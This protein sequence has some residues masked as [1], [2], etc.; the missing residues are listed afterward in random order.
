MSEKLLEEKFSLDGI[1]NVRLERIGG[2]TIWEAQP[3]FKHQTEIF[4]IQKSIRPVQEGAECGCVHASDVSVRFP[5]GSE[6]RPDIAIFC[7]EPDE[8][9]EAITLIPAAVVEII[10]KGYEAKDYEVG[11]PFYLSQGI[12]DI[13]TFDPRT[14]EVRHYRPDGV[15]YHTSPVDLLFV[16]GCRCTV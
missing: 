8:E 1:A 4:R 2:L 9:Y 10:S 16:C 7:R 14:G 11:V 6:K 3:V 15:T 13:A 5:D 12:Q